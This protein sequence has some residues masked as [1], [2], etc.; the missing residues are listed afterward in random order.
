[1]LRTCCIPNTVLGAGDVATEQMKPLGVKTLSE[2]MH[3]PEGALCLLL[4]AVEG[5]RIVQSEE[6]LCFLQLRVYCQLPGD[7]EA[8]AEKKQDQGGDCC[9][10]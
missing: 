6:V 3:N 2:D 8:E 9:G 4:S 5:H 1:M 10:G 7:M